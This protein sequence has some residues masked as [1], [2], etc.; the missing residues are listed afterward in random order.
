MQPTEPTVEDLE[1]LSNL[2]ELEEMY[3][4]EEAL[5]R[6]LLNEQ[7]QVDE[8]EG[9]GRSS[10]SPYGACGHPAQEPEFDPSEEEENFTD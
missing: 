1:E 4:R 7:G 5:E 2:L 9:Y 10:S 3:L 6:D 8:H